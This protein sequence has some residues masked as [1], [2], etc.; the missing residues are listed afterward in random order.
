MKISILYHLYFKSSHNKNLTTE[1][2]KFNFFNVFKDFS[3]LLTLVEIDFFILI[4]LLI[5]ILNIW[6]NRF[7]YKSWLKY[8]SL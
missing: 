6:S 8:E 1:D 7:T 5:I 3:L 4:I 2:S